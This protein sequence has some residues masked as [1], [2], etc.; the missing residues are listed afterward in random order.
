LINK[1]ADFSRKASV[2]QRIPR[3]SIQIQKHFVGLN[4]RNSKVVL[5]KLNIF[6][7]EFEIGRRKPKTV[8]HEDVKTYCEFHA[9]EELG[10]T[11]QI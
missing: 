11:L 10:H 9:R 5:K 6:R 2:I 7:F 1:G 3:L 4:G 8:S